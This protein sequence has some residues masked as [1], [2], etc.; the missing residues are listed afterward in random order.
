MRDH[1]D[2]QARSFDELARLMASDRKVSRRTILRL[3]VI[4][5]GTAIIPLSSDEASAAKPCPD[6]RP[7]CRG[8]CCPSSDDCCNGR[9]TT[10][11]TPQNCFGCGDTCGGG[12]ACC[13]LSGSD[14]FFCESLNDIDHCGACNNTC[15][16]TDAA[17]CHQVCTN[18]AFSNVHCGACDNTCPDRTLCCNGACIDH[19]TDASNCGSCGHVCP[20]GER[21]INGS[22][23]PVT[24]CPPCPP[25]SSCCIYDTPV[26]PKTGVTCC[27]NDP[28]CFAG[29]QNDASNPCGYVCANDQDCVGGN[30]F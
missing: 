3:L 24:Q 27:P 22:C 21:C 11:G 18:T 1:L 6:G 8:K 13:P 7:K 17:C 20:T 9:C 29:C 2:P 14:L 30:C 25:T 15:T 10:V 16:G 5:S 23:A 28:T 4:A 26:G 12:E 19:F